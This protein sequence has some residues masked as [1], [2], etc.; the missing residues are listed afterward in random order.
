MG[1]YI[2]IVLKIMELIL[3]KAETKKEII[4]LIYK[5]RY[6]EQIPVSKHANIKDIKSTNRQIENLEKEVIT[7]ACNL[8]AVNVLSQDISEN[9]K[10]IMSIINF[11]I[12]DLESI[13]IELKE[14]D[15][16][17]I[18]SIYEDKS[19]EKEIIFQKKPELNIRLNKMM[20]LFI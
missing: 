12:I 2:K 4:D 20:K 10:I 19:L 7:K 3:N 6:F 15:G 18:F 13:N 17:Y 16:K 1:Q 14:Q 8:K 11:G 9:H 5:V